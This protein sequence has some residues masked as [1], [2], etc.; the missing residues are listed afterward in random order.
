MVPMLERSLVCHWHYSISVSIR[1][2]P[3]IVGNSYTVMSW[4]ARLPGSLYRLQPKAWEIDFHR[5]HL[6]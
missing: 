1:R 6:P 5:A 3:V 4:S 2:V